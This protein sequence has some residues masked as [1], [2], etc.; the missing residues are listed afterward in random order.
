MATRVVPAGTPTGASGHHLPE[1]NSGVEKDHLGSKSRVRV[2]GTRCQPS[3]CSREA[4]RTVI[5]PLRQQ[6]LHPPG[7]FPPSHGRDPRESPGDVSQH[8][9][10]CESEAA[11]P[12]QHPHPPSCRKGAGFSILF[13]AP[14]S[15]T[16][17]WVV[18]RAETDGQDLGCG[19]LGRC[20]IITRGRCCFITFLLGGTGFVPAAV[21]RREK[22][23]SQLGFFVVFV[24]DGTR[25]RKKQELAAS[26]GAV[27]EPAVFWALCTGRSRSEGGWSSVASPGVPRGWRMLG[28]EGSPAKTLLFISQR[29]LDT[30][31][32]GIF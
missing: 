16:P 18:I 15:F 21:R 26:K 8:H 2:T 30:Q 17:R 28:E 32:D 3:G 27:P 29:K 12:P 22:A 5:A 1:A 11:G 13:T 9:L 23:G 14:G 10:S 24:P 7:S 25:S 19:L 6:P 31:K 20:W 4:V